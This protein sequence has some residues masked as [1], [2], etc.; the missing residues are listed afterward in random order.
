M[1]FKL[2]EAV[3]ATIPQDEAFYLPV[4]RVYQIPGRG[5]SICSFFGEA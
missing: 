2:L 4:E 3:D 5:V 1:A